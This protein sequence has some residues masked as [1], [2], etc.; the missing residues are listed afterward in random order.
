MS[1]L[2]FSVLFERTCEGRLKVLELKL[3]ASKCLIRF[4]F[5]KLESFENFKM[6]APLGCQFYKQLFTVWMSL[7]AAFRQHNLLG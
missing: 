3:C 4:S 1:I 6:R 7:F 2:L 5:S